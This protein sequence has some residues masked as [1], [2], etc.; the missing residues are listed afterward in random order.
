MVCP[1][2][3]GKHIDFQ[4]LVKSVLNVLNAFN[5]IHGVSLLSQSDPHL[6]RL[7]SHLSLITLCFAL[8]EAPLVVGLINFRILSAVN[9]ILRT[10]SDP[11]RTRTS[12]AAP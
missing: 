2:F 4:A 11:E 3:I 12:S 8:N 7:V 1:P 10:G 9:F 5:S 6:L